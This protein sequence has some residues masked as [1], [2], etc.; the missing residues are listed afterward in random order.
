MICPLTF[1]GFIFANVYLS[2]LQSYL[3]KPVL[4]P[5]LKTLSDIYDSPLAIAVPPEYVDVVLDRVAYRSTHKDWRKKIVVIDDQNYIT[6]ISNFN[7]SISYLLDENDFNTLSR[8]QLRLNVRGFYDTGVTVSNSLL[9]FFVNE[10]LLFFDKLNA[11]I[12][13][14]QSSGLN[15]HWLKLYY[16]GLEK[17]ALAMNR[18]LKDLQAEDRFE[19]PMI[20]VYGWIASIILLKTEISWIKLGQR[21]RNKV[22]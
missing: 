18:S 14:L 5:Q 22:C 17:A 21:F 4:Q 8:V 12:H 7:T 20:V 9:V 16:A 2:N 6:E 15:Q 3:T 19:F 11:I 13:R 1:L 10:S